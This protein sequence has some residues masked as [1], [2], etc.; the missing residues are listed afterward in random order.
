MWLIT[1]NAI[2]IDGVLFL[3]NSA[4]IFGYPLRLY[5]Y[6]ELDAYLMF[7]N[8]CFYNHM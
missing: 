4:D 1:K 6:L 7:A 3:C 8:A 5:K 2:R